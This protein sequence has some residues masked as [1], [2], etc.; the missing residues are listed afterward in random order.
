MNIS[1]IAVTSLV[2]FISA[3]SFSAD[4][5]RS[6]RSINGTNA[7]TQVDWTVAL[8][9]DY[10]QPS[11]SGENKLVS[12]YQFCG[13]AL[14]NK[15]W[16]VTAAHCVEDIDHKNISVAVGALDLDE[17]IKS[18][19]LTVKSISKIIIHPKYYS[20]YSPLKSMAWLDNDIALLKLKTEAST[21]QP[22]S[23]ID[24]NLPENSITK[25]SGWGLTEYSSNFE[26]TTYDG[27]EMYLVNN[28]KK[29]TSIRQDVTYEI[30][31]TEQCIDSKFSELGVTARLWKIPK[32][33]SNFIDNLKKLGIAQLKIN[34]K[35]NLLDGSDP[36][37]EEL[38]VLEKKIDSSIQYFV[39]EVS[40]LLRHNILLE[41]ASKNNTVNKLISSSNQL[42]VSSVS[43]PIAGIC[44]GDSG[45]PL[46]YEDNGVARLYGLASFSRGCAAPN[47]LDVFT[48]VYS[49][50]S[51]INSTISSN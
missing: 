25:T 47:S 51:W 27:I 9:K 16:V 15:N 35:I 50:K 30:R 46:F 23:I 29:T 4:H 14:I 17:E 34:K 39:N 48:N 26:K 20:T 11:A 49:Y 3:S 38:K 24:Q 7:T 44:F 36:N 45:S 40:L 12:E 42:C 31:G 1:S 10:D 43:T 13:G 2:I 33:I 41:A 5:I 22:I 37:I 32:A 8:L 6:K 28:S 19:A 21:K 18:N